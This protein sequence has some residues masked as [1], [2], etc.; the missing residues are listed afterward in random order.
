MTQTS[1]LENRRARAQT[2]LTFGG[3]LF[4]VGSLGQL[5][6]TLVKA[7]GLDEIDQALAG[8]AAMALAYIG[9]MLLTAKFAPS[10]AGW[11]WLSRGIRLGCSR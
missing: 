3:T 4:A 5:G 2:L 1:E 10:I 8:Y 9:G 7:Q 11:N 6:L